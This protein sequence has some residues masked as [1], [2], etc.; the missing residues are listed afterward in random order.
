M[1]DSAYVS[2]DNAPGIFH[3]LG[4]ISNY[5]VDSDYEL[6][7]VGFIVSHH[8]VEITFDS[9]MGDEMSLD[10]SPLENLRIAK[11]RADRIFLLEVKKGYAVVNECYISRLDFLSKPMK[12]VVER[13]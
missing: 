3:E 12:L 4:G 9:M 2:F 13:G 6:A 7:P 5:S 11:E 1:S 10:R 8:R